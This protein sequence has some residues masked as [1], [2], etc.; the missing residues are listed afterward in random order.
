MYIDS[1]KISSQ[2]QIKRWISQQ[3]IDNEIN[4]FSIGNLSAIW[5]STRHKPL[6]RRIKKECERKREREI[7]R[8]WIYFFVIDS[9]ADEQWDRTMSQPDLPDRTQMRGCL[10]CN[11]SGQHWACLPRDAQ[12]HII[13][14]HQMITILPRHKLKKS[15]NLH[16]SPVDISVN[17][18][19]I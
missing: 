16:Q 2:Y 9:C 6:H 11:S 15:H 12:P 10:Q 18:Q 19:F 5:N 3:L 14:P 8:G 13:N 7:E 17:S 1:I 4:K